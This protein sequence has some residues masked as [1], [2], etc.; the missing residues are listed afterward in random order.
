MYGALHGFSGFYYLSVFSFFTN[1]C[2]MFTRISPFIICEFHRSQPKGEEG[3]YSLK[4]EDHFAKRMAPFLGNRAR[5]KL[6]YV[7]TMGLYYA[8]TGNFLE[9]PRWSEDYI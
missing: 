7:G 1:A 5:P 9:K 8:K 2:A 4:K 6:H 3:R